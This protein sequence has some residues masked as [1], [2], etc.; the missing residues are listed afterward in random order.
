MRSLLFSMI[1]RKILEDEVI[2][3]IRTVHGAFD[4]S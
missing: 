1:V 2:R 4:N 3:F